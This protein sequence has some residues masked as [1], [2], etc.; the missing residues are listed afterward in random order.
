MIHFDDDITF[1]KYAIGKMLHF[2]NKI[3]N[4]NEHFAK[5]PLGGISFNVIN[6]ILNKSSVFR[7]YFLMNDELGK[8]YRSGI[9]QVI[10]LFQI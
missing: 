8:V 3:K 10:C 2:W 6:A 7:S 5:K 4:N 1:D 9:H